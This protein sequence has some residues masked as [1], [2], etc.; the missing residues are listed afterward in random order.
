MVGFRVFESC[1]LQI[2]RARALLR[3]CLRGSEDGIYP[4]FMT[5]NADLRVLHHEAI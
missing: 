4:L 2:S 3:G 5:G 1:N